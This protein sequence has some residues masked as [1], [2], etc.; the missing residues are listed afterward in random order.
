[1][2]YQ[3]P[4]LQCKVEKIE[5]HYELKYGLIVMPPYNCTHMPAAIELFERIDP[6]VTCIQTIAGSQQDTRYVKRPDGRWGAFK[7]ANL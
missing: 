4:Q 7:P 3:H 2:A 5:Y 1:M 6:N